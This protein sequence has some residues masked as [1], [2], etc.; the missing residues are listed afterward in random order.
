MRDS[1][2]TYHP[3]INFIYFAAVIT[4]TMFIMHPVFLLISFGTALLYYGYLMGR[5]ALLL[6]AV[7][8]LPVI[9]LSA[10]I[11]PLFSHRGA[12][13]LFYFKDGNPVTMESAVY[14]LISGC[15]LASVIIWFACFHEV[16]TS[17]KFIYLFGRLLPVLAFLLTMVF[18]FVPKFGR[19]I[20]RVIQAQKGLGRNT[21]A[22]GIKDKA[23]QGLRILSIVTTWALENSIDT[24]D[25]M[26]SRGYGFRGRT[27]F[28]IYQFEARDTRLLVLLLILS[29]GIAIG[30]FS[31]QITFL[32]FPE[33]HFGKAALETV[34]IYAAFG[35]LSLL[36]VIMDLLEDIKWHYLR[37]RI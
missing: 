28:S 27:S 12:T 11:N 20:T 3:V 34:L 2:S 29:G 7:G 30:F 33:L 23:K 16:M 13:I 22:G 6:L 9:F 5:K 17:D 21:A 26:K 1:F 31:G 32:Y 18:R 25:S 14:G 37:S 24:A 15:M 8:V 19:Q 36:P 35:I 4:F 10:I